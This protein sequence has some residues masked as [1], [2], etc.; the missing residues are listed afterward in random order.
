MND[1]NT[2]QL[3]AI[4]IYV[5]QISERRKK[6]FFASLSRKV[7]ISIDVL[8]LKRRKIITQFY[9]YL[10]VIEISFFVDFSQHRFW[11][12]KCLNFLSD[13][14]FHRE[15]L[16]LCWT[17]SYKC[18]VRKAFRQRQLAWNAKETQFSCATE[19]ERAT[20]QL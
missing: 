13:D 1:T 7:S 5:Y 8:S 20:K 10:L 18:C 19:I 17:F 2:P 6:S 9:F 4:Y 12:H 15:T 14:E 11:F 16:Q 3:M